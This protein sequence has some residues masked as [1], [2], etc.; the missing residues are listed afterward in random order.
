MRSEQNPYSRR[1]KTY[2]LK[3]EHIPLGQL[4]R[5]EVAVFNA[6]GIRNFSSNTAGNYDRALREAKKGC[7]GAI[8]GS[9]MHAQVDSRACSG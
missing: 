7:E 3:P 2:S 6:T 1:A 8:T 5:L 4:N 9:L